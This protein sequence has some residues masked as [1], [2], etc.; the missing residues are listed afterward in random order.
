M[1]LSFF[2]GS[3]ETPACERWCSPL[4][5]QVMDPESS[6]MDYFWTYNAKQKPGYTGGTRGDEKRQ[7]KTGEWVDAEF[8]LTEY[9]KTWRTL[10]RSGQFKILIS[11]YAANKAYKTFVKN[12]AFTKEVS[13]APP[14]A[15]PLAQ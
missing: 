8:D 11:V 13:V 2:I 9:K 5:V 14:S 6:R 7:A 15:P 10:P 1:S 12:I 3:A 4:W